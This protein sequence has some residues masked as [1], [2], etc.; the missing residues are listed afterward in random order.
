MRS[1]KTGIKRTNPARKA[2]NWAR[3]YRSPAFVRFVSRLPCWACGYAGPSPRQCAHTVS[4]GIGR[5]ADAA[6]VIALCNV[7]HARQHQHGWL[8]IGM[9]EESRTRAAS[10]TEAAWLSLGAVSDG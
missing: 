9:T 7:C 3:A 4:G 2:R 5:K 10:Q 6:T 1:R 8:G